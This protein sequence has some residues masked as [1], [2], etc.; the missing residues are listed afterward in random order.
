MTI[1][2]TRN[3]PQTSH[4]EPSPADLYHRFNWE[5]MR[6]NGVCWPDIH[7]DLVCQSWGVTP[8]VLY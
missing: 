2:N 3:R 8:V 7:S 6:G 5:I 4:E 1:T